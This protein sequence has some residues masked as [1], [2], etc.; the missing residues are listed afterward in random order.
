MIQNIAKLSVY[1]RD[2][3]VGVLTTAPTGNCV[4]QYDAQF[5]REQSICFYRRHNR[6]I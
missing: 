1:Y 3:K 5:S 4:F 2:R 6:N